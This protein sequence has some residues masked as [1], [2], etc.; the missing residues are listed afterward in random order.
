M[1]DP[2]TR[3]FTRVTAELLPGLSPDYA[4]GRV[5]TIEGC[6]YQITGYNKTRDQYTL[7]IL[8]EDPGRVYHA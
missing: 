4:V 7:G 2:S 5:V 1:P 8:G 6:K 3:R